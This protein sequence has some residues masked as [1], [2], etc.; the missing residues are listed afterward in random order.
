M[1]N[2]KSRLAKWAAMVAA[3][4]VSG[5]A[6]E[7]ISEVRQLRTEVV[8]LQDYAVATTAAFKETTKAFNRTTVAL[9]ETRSKLRI[10]EHTINNSTAELVSYQLVLKESA[11]SAEGECKAAKAKLDELVRI[12]R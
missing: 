6:Y 2:L 10:V 9:E 8:R 11:S 12:F 7:L 3:L 5:G 1:N 4:V